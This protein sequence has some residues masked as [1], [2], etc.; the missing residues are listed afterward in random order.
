MWAAQHCSMLFSSGK[1]RLCVFCCVPRSAI[2][3]SERCTDIAKPIIVDK[4]SS[5]VPIL[6]SR[7]VHDIHSEIKKYLLSST[8]QCLSI[9]N[10]FYH[11]RQTSD[12]AWNRL[13]TWHVLSYHA[14]LDT[15]VIPRLL[16]PEQKIPRINVLDGSRLE[17][18]NT[19]HSLMV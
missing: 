8:K 3:W 7:R 9:G 19:E 6:N 17:V 16:D 14:W 13:C 15:S 11:N 12:F 10:Y 5:L 2:E 4:F 18:N 1:N